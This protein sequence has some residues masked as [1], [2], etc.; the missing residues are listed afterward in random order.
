MK[1]MACV[2]IFVL[3]LYYCSSYI[4]RRIESVK[5]VLKSEGNFYTLDGNDFCSEKHAS[6]DR[7]GTIKMI[8]NKEYERHSLISVGGIGGKNMCT[9]YNTCKG[10]HEI[11]LYISH[12]FS[13]ECRCME[14]YYKHIS[15]DD[16]EPC[17]V[18]YFCPIYSNKKFQCPLNTEII[19]HENYGNDTEIFEHCKPNDGYSIHKNFDNIRNM[20]QASSTHNEVSIYRVQYCGTYC[21]KSVICNT[22][23]IRNVVNK[24]S[25]C[26]NGYYKSDVSDICTPCK[27]DHFCNNGV[28]EA[29]G[30]NQKT[31]HSLSTYKT[32]CV[33]V[34]GS[35]KNSKNLCEPIIG[36]NHYSLDCQTISDMTCA[37][38]IPCEYPLI[39]RG[40]KIQNCAAGLYNDVENMGCKKCPISSYCNMGKIYACPPGATTSGVGSTSIHFCYCKAEFRMFNETGVFG[41]IVC[42]EDKS[43]INTALQIKS[44]T[45]YMQF[46]VFEIFYLVES[47]NYIYNNVSTLV[48]IDVNNKVLKLVLFM[49]TL[50]QSSIIME[51]NCTVENILSSMQ[52]AGAR[53][54]YATSIISYVNTNFEHRTSNILQTNLL[55]VNEV[56]AQV[57]TC[58]IT[59]HIMGLQIMDS[60]IQMQ[61]MKIDCTV[62]ISFAPSLLFQ[63]ID[64]PSWNAVFAMKF[65]DFNNSTQHTSYDMISVSIDGQIKT[66]RTSIAN[67]IAKDLNLNDLYDMSI[68]MHDS[69]DY[70]I[71]SNAKASVII[72]INTWLIQDKYIPYQ[73][74]IT[75][76]MYVPIQFE[77]QTL[78]VSIFSLFHKQ[79]VV[80]M[81]II[82][83]QIGVIQ[84]KYEICQNNSNALHSNGYVCRC[85]SGYS[86]STTTQSCT[87]C[88]IDIQAS[89]ELVSDLSTVC[90]KNYCKCKLGYKLLNDNCVLCLSTEYCLN[91]QHNL[92]PQHSSSFKGASKVQDCVCDVGYFKDFAER[93]VLC[94][95]PYFCNSSKIWEC[96]DKLQTTTSS[97]SLSQ[98]DCSCIIGYQFNSLTNRCAAIPKGFFSTGLYSVNFE[99]AHPL[100]TATIS[101]IGINSCICPKGSK[102]QRDTS[103]N[104]VNCIKCIG[105]E[106]CNYHVDVTTLPQ[107]C[108]NMQFLVANLNND[109][110]VC[111]NGY[112]RV[113][114]TPEFH[115][116]DSTQQIHGIP[117]LCAPCPNGFFC[118]HYDTT[119][120]P[121]N[122]IQKCPDQM[123]SLGKSSSS[124]F[125]FCENPF[126]V[127]K[128]DNLLK[129]FLCKCSDNYYAQDKKC[130]KCPDNMHVPWRSLIYRI[131]GERSC[132]CNSG[133]IKDSAGQ[134]VP[135]YIGYFCPGGVVDYAIPCPDDTFGPAIGQ[136]S[137]KS[138][139]PCTY[140]DS[141]KQ[142]SNQ[143]RTSQGSFDLIESQP[144]FSAISCFSSF[145]AVDTSMKINL[146]ESKYIFRALSND[147]KNFEIVNHIRHIFNN[148]IL[149]I[150]FV[151]ISN[152]IHFTIT[153]DY[154][155]FIST[156]FYISNVDTI[157]DIIRNLSA[158][159]SIS[160]MVVMHYIF[161]HTMYVISNNVYDQIEDEICY[162]PIASTEI[163]QH[164]IEIICSLFIDHIKDKLATPQ[165]FIPSQKIQLQTTVDYMYSIFYDIFKIPDLTF[166]NSTI[167]VP[168]NPSGVA[169]FY[170]SSVLGEIFE[171][172]RHVL[173]DSRID[174]HNSRNQGQNFQIR[175]AQC[176]ST[177]QILFGECTSVA[178]NINTKI[179]CDVCRAGYE[180]LDNSGKC[181]KCSLS[182]DL[183]CSD[184]SSIILCCNDVDTYCSSN[185]DS[186]KNIPLCNNAHHDYGEECDRSDMHSLTH[187][188]CSDKCELLPGYYST[189]ACSTLCGDNLKAGLEEC[190]HNTDINCDLFSCTKIVNV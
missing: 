132:A 135:C 174:F 15:S 29:C 48:V 105:S 144:H 83:K 53:I 164:E 165:L 94:N 35:I 30:T 51:H 129:R 58:A 20:L 100:T 187:S 28:M 117:H 85:N 133:Y 148:D 71:F 18:S 145:I 161:C 17:P 42:K 180:Y 124:D 3:Q 44:I 33:C 21:Y 113:W 119:D 126:H 2:T 36:N 107:L 110:C 147:I 10:K 103:G 50:N 1:K 123:T 97:G 158:K 70:V 65:V 86:Y 166:K 115:T 61:D 54:A 179:H 162:V 64:V 19:S 68:T 46:N 56:N 4:V 184:T 146:Y 38:A 57:T 160:Y 175:L 99:C 62:K 59:T 5:C 24:I 49:Q 170:S 139:L 136:K 109:A 153:T 82:S 172:T 16:C 167:L 182:S 121:S 183:N 6:T 140:G 178:T 111:K 93:C 151:P 67:T 84:M 34:H 173:I 171:S 154:N 98:N 60:N 13:F 89:C 169:I 106:I 25:A 112:Y 157:W 78:H 88:G 73:N 90:Y 159:A 43:S 12:L 9:Q 26:E 7:F 141:W 92:C 120:G 80:F 40:G 156:L 11:P 39:C 79:S 55:L 143:I 101:S 152:A 176:N 190:D 177:A 137:I 134:C 127:L 168:V 32:D 76:P 150:E 8:S 102:N 81:D 189:P 23:R 75:S 96:E 14:G 163:I 91:S 72:D 149:K 108:N 116:I 125:C 104:V 138:C 114:E 77:K 87:K 185:D 128:F 118:S 69:Y 186:S 155:F 188:C 31:L 63:I 22:E 41:G 131:D 130:M 52:I 66:L 47:N 74:S 142:K 37:I 95:M 122:D 181:K 27:Q 45:R